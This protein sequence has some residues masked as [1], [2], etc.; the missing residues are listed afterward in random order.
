MKMTGRILLVSL[1]AMA[2]VQ[3]VY[4]QGEDAALVLGLNRDFG[5]GGLG[6]D[7]EGLFTISATGPEDLVRV[8]FYIDDAL[9]ASP[10]VEPFAYQFSTSAYAPGLHTLHALGYLS[11]GTELRS[12]E[13]ARNFL[14]KEQSQGAIW[15]IL[16]PVFAA[17]ILTMALGAVIPMLFG[18]RM[19]FTGTYG[20]LGGAICPK[21]GLPY[22]LSFWAPRLVVGRLQ[23]CPHC[24]KWAMVRRARPEDL[25]RAE[26]RWRGDESSAGGLQDGEQRA[27]RQIDESR[28]DE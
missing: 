5:Y 17:V 6:N 9:M 22:S 18:R 28:Y 7:I 20:I 16:V 13:I 11:E 15:G 10:E 25:A 19:K 4:A 21:C 23:R 12:N 3:P 24:G 14:T 1:L 27:R 26:A 8:D 2:V